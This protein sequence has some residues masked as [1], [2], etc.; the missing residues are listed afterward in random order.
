MKKITTKELKEKIDSGAEFKLINVLSKESFE[1]QHIPK[2][3]NVPGNELEERAPK[4]LPDKN[5]Q[6]IIYCSSET[7]QASVNAGKK[8]EEIGYTN[9]AHFKEGLAG[10]LDAGFEF[11]K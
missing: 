2:S 3:I 5:E 7:C 6:I 4:E 9:V 8:L 1:A 10:W 11:E